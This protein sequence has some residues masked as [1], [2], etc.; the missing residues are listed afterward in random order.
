MS[1]H[2]HMSVNFGGV[3]IDA[4]EYSRDIKDGKGKNRYDPAS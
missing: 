1:S 3:S 4:I 2:T